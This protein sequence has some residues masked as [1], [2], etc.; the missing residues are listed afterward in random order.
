VKRNKGKEYAE[1]TMAGQTNIF[2]TQRKLAVSNK[3]KYVY[4]Q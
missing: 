2:K 3:Y 1:P 4:G